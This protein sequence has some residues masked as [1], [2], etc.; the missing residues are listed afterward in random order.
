MLVRFCPRVLHLFCKWG[1][2][3]TDI[4]IK[5]LEIQNAVRGVK[6]DKKRESKKI[7]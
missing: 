2:N 1:G 7:I 3:V 4:L 6:N 5:L